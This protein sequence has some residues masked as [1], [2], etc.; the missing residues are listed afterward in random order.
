M[1][2]LEVK[3]AHAANIVFAKAGLNGQLSGMK[4]CSTIKKNGAEVI[5]IPC[6][7]NCY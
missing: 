2:V 4:Q 5:L 3:S 1:R 6:L 7:R